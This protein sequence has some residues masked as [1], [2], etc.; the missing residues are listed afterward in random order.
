M[1]IHNWWCPLGINV[2]VETDG[3]NDDFE[4]PVLIVKKFNREM[5]WV[6]PVTSKD[7]GNKFYFKVKYG[8]K[9]RWIIWSQLRIVSTKR[10]LRKVDVLAEDSFSQIISLIAD[11]L[12]SETPAKAGGSRSPKA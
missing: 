7:K 1:P 3:K 6:L 2:G 10:L 9:D 12:K 4:R 11:S 5:V 8:N